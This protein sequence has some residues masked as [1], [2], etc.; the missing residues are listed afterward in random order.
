MSFPISYR[1]ISEMMPKRA[2]QTRMARAIARKAGLRVGGGTSA[3]R[4]PTT[5]LRTVKWTTESIPP[6]AFGEIQYSS[7]ARR[8]L[9]QSISS[10][11]TISITGIQEITRFW[12]EG[13]TQVR[14]V[15]RVFEAQSGAHLLCGFAPPTFDALNFL[16]A[17]RLPDTYA[18]LGTG[19]QV[20]PPPTST[21]VM[22]MT[23]P[24]TIS[25]WVPIHENFL[26]TEI[27]CAFFLRN[28]NT[29]GFVIA[30]VGACDIQIR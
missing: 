15:A 28:L 8:R 29:S 30:D 23:A 13:F 4:P 18:L 3:G 12:L 22:P 1:E 2:L 7:Y 10:R 14:I 9:G 11:T 27:Q 17:A 6:G 25:P 5:I 21:I 20:I 26:S 19:L 16:A 24:Y